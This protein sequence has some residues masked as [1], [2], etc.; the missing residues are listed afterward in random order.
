MSQGFIDPFFGKTGLDSN[1]KPK[2][3]AASIPIININP[4]KDDII[5]TTEDYDDYEY[6]ETPDRWYYPW[7]YD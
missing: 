2:V 4:Q 1:V 6:D 7:L 5:T 3:D